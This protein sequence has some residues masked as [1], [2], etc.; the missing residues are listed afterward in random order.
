MV[1]LLRA[2]QGDADKSFN[3]FRINIS[4]F[5]EVSVGVSVIGT[6]MLP[7]FLEANCPKLLGVLSRFTRHFTSGRRFGVLV[8][9]KGDTMVASQ[10]FAHS[11]KITIV[12]QPSESDLEASTNHD[13]DMERYPSYE[14][15]HNCQDCSENESM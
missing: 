1:Y 12:E 10:E 13:D 4:A 6:F 7:K 11:D 9:W 5:A 3:D 14:G 2:V 8:R 15:V